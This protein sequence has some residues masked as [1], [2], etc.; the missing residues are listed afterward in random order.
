MTFH[1][2]LAFEYAAVRLAL[3]DQCRRW[4]SPG[5]NT[6]AC[7]YMVTPGGL[8][9]QDAALQC[10]QGGC[11]ETLAAIS[12]RAEAR[13]LDSQRAAPWIA[14]CVHIYGE[15]PRGSLAR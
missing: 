13:A 4:L 10:L 14:R 15:H 5:D 8:S 1:A 2:E 3:I 11:R 6:E 7:E 12:A 9:Y